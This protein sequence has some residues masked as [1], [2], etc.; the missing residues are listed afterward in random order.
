[1]CLAIPME[2]LRVDGLQAWC[3]DR[4]GS[5][6]VVDTILTGP[7]NPGQWLLVFLGAAREIVSAEDA[8]KVSA[9]ID[10]LDAALVGDTDRI[11]AAFADLIDREPQLPDFLRKDA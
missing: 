6:V 7:V 10:A 11:N 8:A 2:V 3:R 9:A 1:M 5:E 4:D